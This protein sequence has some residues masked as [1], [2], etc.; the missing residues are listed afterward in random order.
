MVEIN[1]ENYCFCELAPLYALDLL[2]E[3]ERNWV[4]QQI[5][6]CPEL[7]AELAEYELAV[8]AIPY[9]TPSISMATDLKNRLFERLELDQPEPLPVKETVTPP[10][11][12]AVRSPDFNWQP[13]D[14]PG[15]AIAILR[16]DEV[17]REIVGVLRADPG[18]QYPYHRHAGLEELYMISGELVIDDQV[19]SAG[20]YIRSEPGSIHGPYTNGG[21]MFFFHTSMDNEYLNLKEDVKL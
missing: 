4:E 7:S 9:A 17:K 8:T 16:I 20:D 5:A 3:Q 14:V 12:F 1:H 10:A 19:Y 13:H 21:C 2:N 18:V 6:E 11:F 15:V